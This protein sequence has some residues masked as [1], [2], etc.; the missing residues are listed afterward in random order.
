MNYINRRKFL[1]LSG[2]AAISALAAVATAGV[3]AAA[4]ASAGTPVI[5]VQACA[6]VNIRAGA[7][8][9]SARIGKLYDGD[10][11]TVFAISADRNW[12]CIAFRRGTAW[13]NASA[14]LT[15]PIAWRR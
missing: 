6:T 7:S 4:P 8:L 5:C 15:K 10:T 12:W 2:S 3:A 13:V 1:Q 14:D 11:A 9:R